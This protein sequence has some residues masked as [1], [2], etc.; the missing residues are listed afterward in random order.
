VSADVPVSRFV[1][2]FTGSPGN[3]RFFFEVETE[4]GGPSYW[5]LAEKTQVADFAAQSA[6]LLAEMGF[7]G[8]GAQLD[9]APLREPTAVA[10]RVAEMTIEYRESAGLVVVTLGPG[11]ESEP[12]AVHAITPAQLDAAVQIGTNAVR[13]GRPPCPRCGLAMDPTGHVCPTTNGDL[14]GHRP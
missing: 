13:A 12:D 4:P 2:G 14:R 7:T 1:P 5:Y 10:F 8:A 11:D 3:R 6:L 9:L